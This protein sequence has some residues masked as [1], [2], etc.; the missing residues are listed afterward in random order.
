MLQRGETHLKYAVEVQ[1][2]RA[3]PMMGMLEPVLERVV[4]EDIPFNLAAVKQRVEECK[5]QRRIAEL[6]DAGAQ[7]RCHRLLSLE[8]FSRS[9][10][11]GWCTE[12]GLTTLV[13]P[14]MRQLRTKAQPHATFVL[15]IKP[16]RQGPNPL[17]TVQW[18]SRGVW[19]RGVSEAPGGAPA[20]G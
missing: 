4:Y 6:E 11:Q 13:C 10:V 16:Q 20:P 7:Q 19:S 17:L 2:P 5:L 12:P 1:I 3:T 15:M 18:V 9:T 14:R 8:P